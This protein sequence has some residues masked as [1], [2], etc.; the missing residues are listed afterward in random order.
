MTDPTHPLFGRCFRI[1]S[2]SHSPQAVGHVVVV[3]RDGMRLWLPIRATNLAAD[4]LPV[5]RT[6]FTADAL[7]SFLAFVKECEGSCPVPQDDCGAD[8]PMS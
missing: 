3:Y 5:T 4:N 7:C 2:V 1:L 6:K 8:S